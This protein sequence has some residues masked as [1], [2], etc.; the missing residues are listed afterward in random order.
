MCIWTRTTGVRYKPR[1]SQPD[2]PPVAALQTNHSGHRMVL[3]TDLDGTFLGGSD[4]D[5]DAL[6]DWLRQ[7][8]E[9]VGLIFVTGRDPDFIGELCASGRIPWP[10]YVVGD[11]GTTI[12]E[13]TAAGEIRPIQALE[14][15]IANLWQDR[16]PSVR[17][18]LH[19][20]PGLTLQPTGFRYRVSYD[21]DPAHFDESAVQIVAE[22]GADSLISDN[23]FFDVLPRNVS[24][25][26]SLIRL[27]NH[28]KVDP[29]KTLAAG[30]T[31][32]DLSM[33][34]AGTPAVAVGGAETALLDA[35]PQ[36][37]HIYRA[38]NIGAAGIIEAIR[39][40]ALHPVT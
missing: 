14:E 12:A 29:A 33:L 5:R 17:E 35:L 38:T 39:H 32:N 8:S 9:T 18:K 25:G 13:V 11:V 34:V 26:P 19:N 28:L 10:S 15:A 1:M 37:E 27:L 36:A 2:M 23:R 7:H 6:Y 3:A 20:H 40:F 16:G 24:K 31:L 30:D 4:A 21:M 22:L